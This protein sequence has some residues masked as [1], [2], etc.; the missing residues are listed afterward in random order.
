M[1]RQFFRRALVCR[2]FSISSTRLTDE[3]IR[4]RDGGL[5]LARWHFWNFSDVNMGCNIALGGVLPAPIDG[6]GG[7]SG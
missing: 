6:N 4:S 1:L 7:G 3:S 2:K 5:A